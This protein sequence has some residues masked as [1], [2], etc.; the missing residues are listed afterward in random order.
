MWRD[1][2]RPSQIDRASKENCRQYSRGCRLQWIIHG[3]QS[4]SQDL[5]TPCQKSIIKSRCNSTL[6]MMKK[7]FLFSS[8]LCFVSL[9][10]RTFKNVHLQIDS[11]RSSFLRETET[12]WEV[13]MIQENILVMWIYL[14]RLK[15]VGFSHIGISITFF[16]PSFRA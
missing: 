14:L 16:S 11:C 4:R 10:T 7:L 5:I 1:K 2:D 12:E 13:K 15:I 6:K 9:Y 8:F 3:N